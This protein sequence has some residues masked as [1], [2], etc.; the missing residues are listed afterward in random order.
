M[1]L[2]AA[3]FPVIGLLVLIALFLLLKPASAPAPVPAPRTSAIE[4]AA[5]TA[6]PI[7][8]TASHDFAMMIEHGSKRSG[9]DV[10]QVSAGDDVILRITSDKADVLHVHGYD[11]HARLEPG[12]PAVLHFKADRS[13]R[14]TL[15][16]HHSNLELGALEVLP[17]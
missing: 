10:M 15:E 11:L 12:V 8:T 5:T 2:K 9:P 17:R 6:A 13:G 16:L 1:N 14:F 7:V 3:L 4:G